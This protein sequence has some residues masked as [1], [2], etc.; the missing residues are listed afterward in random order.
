MLCIGNVAY[1]HKLYNIAK[2]Q[3]PP[4]QT[5]RPTHSTPTTTEG[6]LQVLYHSS[7]L[8]QV[9]FTD[10]ALLYGLYP[11]YREG[12]HYTLENLS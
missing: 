5:P 1:T 12:R 8:L 3:R 9:C 7:L 10:Y 2:A 11:H 4:K 6:A